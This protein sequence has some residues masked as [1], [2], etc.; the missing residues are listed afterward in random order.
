MI[1]EHTPFRE[2][3]VL[4]FSGESAV[5]RM[6][7][8]LL[9]I[10]GEAGPDVLPC[11]IVCDGD[12]FSQCTALG[13]SPYT[14]LPVLFYTTDPAGFTPPAFAARCLVLR[15]PFLFAEF[16]QAVAQLRMQ[17]DHHPLPEMPVSVS[18]PLIRVENQT[19]VYKDVRIPLSPCEAGILTA[20]TEAYPN[21]AP[22]ER[23]EAVFARSGSNSVSVYIS[24]LR[25]KLSA[26]PA[27]RAV[28][29]VK[30][31]GFALLMHVPYDK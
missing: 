23:L 30:G 7:T 1:T 14:T 26:I 20:L 12:D 29:S 4:F 28:I 24:Y 15:R 31:G 13:K 11:L 18:A 9:G 22:R 21:A 17:T 2:G 6:M 16:R 19:A 3:E 27:F 10:R 8:A 25:K 5:V